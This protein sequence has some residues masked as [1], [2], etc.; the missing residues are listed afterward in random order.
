MY[1]E[2]IGRLLYRIAETDA[3]NRAGIVAIETT[4]DDPPGI[5][6]S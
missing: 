3:F 2:A 1:R 6:R 5:S 4:G